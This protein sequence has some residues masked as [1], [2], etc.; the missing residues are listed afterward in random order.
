MF[1]II[2]G[3][4]YWSIFQST[5]NETLSSV[6]HRLNNIRLTSQVGICNVWMSGQIGLSC[7]IV[8]SE[9]DLYNVLY[10][11]YQSSRYLYG[12]PNKKVCTLNNLLS[13]LYVST[14]IFCS[15]VK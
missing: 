3:Q 7:F 11:M 15:P 6:E 14:T 8:A 4:Y 10:T 5:F 12:V 9:V 13:I 1:L 2:F